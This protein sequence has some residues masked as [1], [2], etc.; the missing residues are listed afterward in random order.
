MVDEL[1]IQR[2]QSALAATVHVGT[3]GSS[4]QD[5][6]ATMAPVT[7][8]VNLSQGAQAIVASGGGNEGGD[9][10]DKPL[11]VGAI[12]PDDTAA[13]ISLNQAFNF[14]VNDIN[15]LV[16]ALGVS[17][18][19]VAQVASSVADQAKALGVGVHPPIAALLM[20]AQQ[21]QSTAALYVE[22]LDLTI[23]SGKTVSVSVGR[24]AVT[25][26][27]GSLGEGQSTDGT[28]LV[29]DV[30]GGLKL[31]T[32]AH[33]AS[34]DEWAKEAINGRTPGLVIVRSG[35]TVRQEGTLRLTLDLL[36]PIQ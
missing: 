28:P 12:V 18:F 3:S 16:G 24:V 11:S 8:S 9:I 15:W 14:A 5:R 13:Q 26:V 23:Q 1:E 21:S 29:V 27:H 17:P 6:S 36:H 30:G 25:N 33:A 19:D 20:H 31:P 10:A 7:D 4:S 35:G 22:N 34:D 2:T 32:S